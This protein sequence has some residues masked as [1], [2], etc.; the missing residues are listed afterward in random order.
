MFIYTILSRITHPTLLMG[1][2]ESLNE[3]RKH[4]PGWDYQLVKVDAGDVNLTLLDLTGHSSLAT[5]TL[6]ESQCINQVKA[7]RVLVLLRANQVVLAQQLMQSY[8][9]SVL[10]VD[11]RQL[12][13][14]E[15]VE[16]SMKIRRYISPLFLR[17]RES[18]ALQSEAVHFTTAET[19]V[20]DGLRFGKNGVQLSNELFRSQKTISTHK[21][22]IM[23]KLGAK[24]ELELYKAL[25]GITQSE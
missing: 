13:L 5:L 11:E 16:C 2:L 14:R 17:V 8:S 24:S 6:F 25:Q 9:C 19:R 12:R 1:F 23:K 20:L 22:N 10:C 3:L 7:A 15:L 4:N 21:R 18:A